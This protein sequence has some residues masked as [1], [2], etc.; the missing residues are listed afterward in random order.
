MHRCPRRLAVLNLASL[1][2]WRSVHNRRVSPISSPILLVGPQPI[3]PA[4]SIDESIGNNIAPV[5]RTVSRI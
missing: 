2:L 1:D 4:V 5:T 3:A